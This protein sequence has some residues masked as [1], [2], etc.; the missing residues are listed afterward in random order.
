MIRI[1]A[2]IFF[3]LFSLPA[4]TKGINV[5]SFGLYDIKFD[6][7]AKNEAVDFRYEYRSDNSLIDIGPEEDNFFFLETFF[8]C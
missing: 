7:S 2:L 3:I 6:N 8:W 1:F 5:F 4:L